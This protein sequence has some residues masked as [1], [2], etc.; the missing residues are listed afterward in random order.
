M[1]NNNSNTDQ[2]NNNSNSQAQGQQGDDQNKGQQQGQSNTNNQESEGLKNLRKEFE[3]AQAKIKSFESEKAESEKKALEE[4]G[5]WKEIA[6]KREQEANQFKSQYQETLKSQHVRS[7]L[8][9][10]GVSPAN[11]DIL[12]GHVKQQVE[13]G[14]DNIGSN[15]AD[16]I[17]NLKTS[18][19]AFFAP[20][21]QQA[22]KTSASGNQQK[23]G[24]DPSDESMSKEDIWAN[25]EEIKKKYNK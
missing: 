13:F 22:G 1:D 3:K 11:I 14:D 18:S 16:I 24:F 12:E 6:E 8:A 19:P 21:T 10:A 25:L 17:N 5:K 2:Q 4:Q 23:S 20:V 15:T 9:K 7:E